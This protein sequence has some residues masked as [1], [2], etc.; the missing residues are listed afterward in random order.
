[1][2]TRKYASGYSKIQKKR[3]VE[4]L[5]KSQ[6]GA[7]DKFLTNNEKPKSQNVGECSVDEQVTNLVESDDNKIQI[8]EEEIYEKSDED[9]QKNQ[10]LI[11]EL[12]N[13]I[14]KNIYDPSQWT[15]V[16]IK[17]RDL[18]VEKGPTRITD[19]DFPKDKFLRHFS[20]THYF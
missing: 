9:S 5:I 20:T 3:K 18:L 17:L 16:D 4:N 12:N 14:P 19:I 6:K 15:N 1:M 11:N 8:E 13:S 7:L 10:E 2:S